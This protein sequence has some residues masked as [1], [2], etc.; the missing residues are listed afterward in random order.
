MDTSLILTAKTIRNHTRTVSLLV[1]TLVALTVILTGCDGASNGDESSQELHIATASLGG[2]FYPVGQTASNL[3]TKYADHVTMLPVVS[4]GAIQNPR[5][6]HSGEVDVG[7]TNGNMAWLAVNAGGPYASSLDLKALGTLHPSIL[8]MVT[9]QGSGIR[10]FDDLKGKRVAVGPAGGG[11]YGFLT[12]LLDAHDLTIDDITPSYLSYTDGFAQLGDGNVDAA[13][14]LAAFPTAAVIQTLATH[15]LSFIELSS[16]KLALMLDKYP[17]YTSRV[18]P[19]A[20]YRL[21]QN[22]TV[23]GVNN[24][25]IVH[26]GMDEE[27]VFQIAQAIYGHME[28]FQRS[29]AIAKQIDAKQSLRLPIELHPGA[30]RYFE[31]VSATDDLI[32]DRAAE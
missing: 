15:D 12:R 1:P 2:A 17:Y 32:K 26:S 7:M 29:N 23:I 19:R 3:V 10:S 4:A 30:A 20:T 16:E 27:Q 22:V 31:S 5:L 9:L 14:A 21:E 24:M 6:V 8:H 11:T 18:L 28:E 25:M 13:L